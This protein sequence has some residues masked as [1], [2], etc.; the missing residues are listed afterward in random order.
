M[1]YNKLPNVKIYCLRMHYMVE[2]IWT[3]FMMFQMKVVYGF[4]EKNK[5]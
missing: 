2:V 5:I 4:V 3:V 1:N